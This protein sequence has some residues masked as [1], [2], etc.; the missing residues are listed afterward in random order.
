MHH[1][2]TSSYVYMFDVDPLNGNAVDTHA[3]DAMNR[4][5]LQGGALHIHNPKSLPERVSCF[6]CDTGANACRF[7]IVRFA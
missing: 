2:L 4:I 7:T 5:C 3:Q 1:N 6:V